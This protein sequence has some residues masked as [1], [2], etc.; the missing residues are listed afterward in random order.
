[1]K[2]NGSITIDVGD[3]AIKEND[4]DNKSAGRLNLDFKRK[5]IIDNNQTRYYYPLEAYNASYTSVIMQDKVNSEV[6]K[7]IY[8]YVN[9]IC[10][11]D[12][13]KVAFYTALGRERE[14]QYKGN[15]SLLIESSIP[16]PEEQIPNGFQIGDFVNYDAGTWKQEDIEAIKT[17]LKTDLSTANGKAELPTKNFQ[18]GGF[19]AG[20]SR[21]GN[22]TPASTQYNY[23]K[24]KKLDG[25]EVAI[26]GWR[27]FDIDGDIVTLISAGTP[28]D[29][30]HSQPYSYNPYGGYA[31][32]SE[33]ILTENV[34]GSWSNGAEE[35]Q[36]YQIR[37][38]K[39]YINTAQ[40]AEKATVLTKKKLDSW[41][42]KYINIVN[43]NVKDDSTFQKIYY[44]ASYYK[45]QNIIDNFSKYNLVTATAEIGH[46]VFMP[47]SPG[48]IGN[49]T[50]YCKQGIRIL[51]TLSPDAKFTKANPGTKTLTGG[52]MD[53]YGGDQTYN[54]WDIITE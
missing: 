31:Y 43:A 54:V 26:T 3:Y 27:V 23:I 45:Y 8:E 20:S 36:N 10:K 7:D 13:V 25:T 18:F 30:Y 53:K 34:N 14:S 32:E 46:Y 48:V 21:N 35:S 42:T 51:V 4:T 1:M 24:E 47:Y 11:N 40:K 50:G 39:N 22:A 5:S 6:Y 2:K 16:E 12:D 33:Y 29:Y 9:N 38:W 49:N 52:N 17:G 19:T 15:N 41:Y 44:D 37:D 28:E